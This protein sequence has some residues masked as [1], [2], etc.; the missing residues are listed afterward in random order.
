MS[1][2][3]RLANLART[4]MVVAALLGFQVSIYAAETAADKMKQAV[5]VTMYDDGKS[6]PHDCDAHV[7]FKSRLNGTQFAHTPS[8]VPAKYE[9][10]PKDADCEIC[11][12][13]ERKE[14]LTVMYRGDGPGE[15][16]FD[17]TPAFFESRC[18][19]TSIPT[20]LE[21]ECLRLRVAAA[22]L[23]GTINCFSNLDHPKCKDIMASALA[24]KNADLPIFNECKRVTE[25]KFNRGK[26]LKAQRINDCAYEAAINGGPNK[27]GTRW[28]KLLPGAC[29][30][31]TYVGRDGLDCCSGSSFKDGP[32]LQECEAFH[33]KS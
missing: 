21:K 22:K 6:C 12:A 4:P 16:T 10:C 32:L 29:R 3:R 1:L 2:A 23:D 9:D 27:H 13:V 20:L 7:V 25:E 11:L 18:G 19:T 8:S 28:N 30:P 24:R 26:P 31:G 15:M 17:F 33:P 5:R 14:C